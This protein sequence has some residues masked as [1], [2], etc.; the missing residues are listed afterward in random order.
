MLSLEYSNS[1][2]SNISNFTNKT[3]D[4]GKNFSLEVKIFNGS[5]IKFNLWGAAKFNKNGQ[6]LK[7]TVK[8]A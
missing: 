2:Q 7:R 4:N 6:I 5:Y 1:I 3:M 8:T